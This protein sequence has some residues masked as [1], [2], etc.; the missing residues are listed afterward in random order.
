M[1]HLPLILALALGVVLA[2]ATPAL[3]Y[4]GPGAGITMLTALWGVVLA[5]LLAVGAILVWP[6]R[7]LMRRR[8]Q[9]VQGEPADRSQAG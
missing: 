3:A 4:F 6:I 9:S 8:R 1:R 5:V 7:A 2:D